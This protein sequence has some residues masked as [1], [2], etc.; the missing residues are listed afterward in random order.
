[1]TWIFSV[2]V[3]QRPIFDKL[4]LQVE[5]GRF[6]NHPR[7]PGSI[8]PLY[9]TQIVEF[10]SR[11]DRRTNRSVIGP[12]VVAGNLVRD[13]TDGS[14][15]PRRGRQSEFKATAIS[16]VLHAALLLFLAMWV[17]PVASSGSNILK[18]SAG[19]NE[20]LALE[21]IGE[22]ET[23]EPVIEEAA[24]DGADVELFEIAEIEK[25]DLMPKP[26]VTDAAVASPSSVIQPGRSAST[27]SRSIEGAV[28]SITGDLD[29]RLQNGDLLVVWLLDA[30]H[31]L[32]DDRR[33]VAER[34]EPFYARIADQTGS[35]PHQLRSAVVSFGNAM[36]ERV[37][38]TEFG[39]RIVNAV[40]ELPIDKTG[41]EKVFDAVAKCAANYRRRRPDQQILIV[42]WTDESGDDEK[43]LEQTIQVCREQRVAVSVVGPSSVLGADTG[44][45]SYLEPESRSVYQLPVRRGPDAAEPERLEL[46][47]WFAP[48]KLGRRRAIPNWY[49]G[50]NMVGV[51][52]G[53]SPY[54]LTRLTIQT[55]GQYT[56]FDRIDDRAPFDRDVMERYQ[57]SYLSRSEYDDEIRSHPLRRAVMK[58]VEETRGEKLGEPPSQLFIKKTGEREFDFMRYYYPPDQ[59]RAKLRSSRGRMKSQAL[60]MS[61]V[62]EK[63]LRHVSEDNALRHGLDDLYQYEESARWRAWYDLT[64]GR[65]LAA[66]VRL[67]EYRLTL[68]QIAK[69][70][71]LAET[72]NH[73]IFVA[74]Q[75][76]QGDAE[77]RRRGEEAE[78]LLRRCV[79]ENEGTPWQ[80]LAEQELDYAL[81]VG[82]RE[83][84][85]TLQR[86]GPAP[87][88]PTLPRF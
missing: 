86:G 35:T 59:F 66:S 45:H 7:L 25:F 77:Y 38:P 53:F 48:R 1:M 82:V 75:D 26:T 37:A 40:E 60:R 31:S 80:Y 12:D 24:P 43:N 56:V 63:A 5:G 88:G 46:G 18:F 9:P 41:N 87:K 39:K 62:V 71:S 61:R 19:E 55:G 78:R 58:A 47:Y 11:I 10:M 67:E 23:E 68:D 84:A 79:S 27:S 73:V 36:R 57:P 28:D 70:G 34:L 32:V 52:C 20:Q 51:L 85:L 22:I 64:R 65:L 81:G 29:S 17:L 42:I 83:M 54:A 14:D 15:L 3:R 49:G 8:T 4:R 50:A 13:P 74:T 21:A 76:T 30:S 6:G 2:S 16:A 33:R 69:P 44:L 72:T